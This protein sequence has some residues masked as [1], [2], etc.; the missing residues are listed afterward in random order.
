MFQGTKTSHVLKYFS[1]GVLC[2]EKWLVLRFTHTIQV[3]SLRYTCCVS[4][5]LSLAHRASHSLVYMY[6][7]SDILHKIIYMFAQIL[8]Q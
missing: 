2:H 3:E 8:S 4:R 5:I 6:I 7:Y 1:D